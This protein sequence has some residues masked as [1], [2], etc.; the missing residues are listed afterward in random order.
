MNHNLQKCHI[1]FPAPLY[2][3][4]KLTVNDV[5]ARFDIENDQLKVEKLEASGGDLD[6]SMSGTI[7]IRK[8]ITKSVLNLKG[9]V[10]P[11]PVILDKLS[12]LGP[13]FKMFVAKRSG[14]NNIPVRLT[15]TLGRPGF[16]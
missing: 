4:E 3:L 16:F 15:G 14:D 13:M 12:E 1:V 2:G 5:T 6:G 9:G 8:P 7:T 11:G 10:N